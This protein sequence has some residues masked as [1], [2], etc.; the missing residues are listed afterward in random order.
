MLAD[1]PPAIPAP[2][3]R[4]EEATPAKVPLVEDGV[5]PPGARAQDP[6]HAARKQQAR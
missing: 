3:G 4:D 2:A 6:D 5:H 1:L